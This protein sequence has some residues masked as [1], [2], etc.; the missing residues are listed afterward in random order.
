[1]KKQLDKQSPQ[2][3]WILEFEVRDYECDY[4]GVVNNSVYLNYLEHARHWTIRQHFSVPR[5]SRQGIDLVVAEARLRYLRPLR[6]QDRFAI[7]T[8]FAL[9]GRF[10]LIFEQTIVK[11]AEAAAGRQ[12]NP[13]EEQVLQANICVAA[14]ESGRP[15]PFSRVTDVCGYRFD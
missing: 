4:Q 12:E 8:S 11:P 15:C 10:R 13:A 6:P 3:A 5:L 14:L 7:H 9:Q 1:M 2:Q